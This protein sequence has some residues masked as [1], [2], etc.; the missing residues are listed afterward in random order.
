MTRSVF[1]P[2]DASESDLDWRAD[3]RGNTYEVV[4]TDEHHIR[5]RMP[6]GD[7]WWVRKSCLLSPT[8]KQQDVISRKIAVMYKRFAN[9]KES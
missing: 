4:G 6:D 3:L 2:L 1:I 9:R 7:T 5:L 8:E